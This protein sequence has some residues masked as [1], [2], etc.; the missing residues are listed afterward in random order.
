MRLRTR[1]YQILMDLHY[2]L[3]LWLRSWTADNERD[4]NTGIG[5][6]V[7]VYMLFAVANVVMIGVETGCV[8][9]LFTWRGLCS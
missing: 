5:S 7:G 2:S 4:P 9:A 3:A 8:Q 6:W 1:Q